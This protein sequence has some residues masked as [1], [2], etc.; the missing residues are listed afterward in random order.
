MKLKVPSKNYRAAYWF[1]LPFAYKRKREC[2]VSPH[3]GEVARSARG[4]GLAQHITACYKHDVM[5]CAKLTTQQ[6]PHHSARWRAVTPCVSTAKCKKALKGC[7]GKQEFSPTSNTS[8]L[9]SLSSETVR[10]TVSEEHYTSKEALIKSRLT[11]WHAFCLH[12]FCYI[13]NKNVHCEVLWLLLL[14]LFLHN[15]HR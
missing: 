11:A 7:G 6:S 3:V 9:L 5:F 4:A 14:L 2:E 12:L 13:H 15:H 10:W 8:S 1:S